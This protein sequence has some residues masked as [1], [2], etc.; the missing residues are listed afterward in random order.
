ML[1]GELTDAGRGRCA[2]VTGANT[3]IGLASAL[4]LA[5]EGFQVVATVRS[6]GKA[7]AVYEAADIADVAIETELLE[8]TD[9]EACADVIER[10]R[11]FALVNNAG[12][13]SVSALE[14]T[15][16]EDARSILEINTVAPLRLARLALP[17][18]RE[19]GEGRIV[20]VSSTEGRVVL[21][22]LGWYQ[23]SKHAL[24]AGSA[25]LRLE[26]ARDGIGVSTVEPGGVDT[27]IYQKGF[28]VDEDS[29][30]ESRYGPAYGRLRSLM[31]LN[32]RTQLGPDA[33]AEVVLRAIVSSRPRARYLVGADARALVLTHNLL[34]FPVRERL[35]RR[36]FAL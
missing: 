9:A 28:W 23:A 34:P 24:E 17:H 19:R 15:G 6:P 33:V 20:N 14:D 12:V 10:R 31:R 4:M 7:E 29:D 11:P 8:V 30:A 36:M 32:R 16:D 1:R 25:T 27:A 22:L 18:M 3:G 5:R 35:H 26:T 13:N 2:L 21:P